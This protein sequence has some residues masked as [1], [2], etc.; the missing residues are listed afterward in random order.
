MDVPFG[1]YQI[2]IVVINEFIDSFDNLKEE[3]S[4]FPITKDKHESA[5][6]IR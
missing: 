5:E 1:N 4:S 6:D 3:K 2:I